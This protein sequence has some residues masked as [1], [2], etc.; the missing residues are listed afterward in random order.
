MKVNGFRKVCWGFIILLISELSMKRTK[1]GS[2]NA[3]VKNGVGNQE[4]LISQIVQG[5][6]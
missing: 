2:V 3:N 1:Q 4:H 6:A 5:V